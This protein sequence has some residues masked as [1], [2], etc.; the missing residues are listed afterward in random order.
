MAFS[1]I[2]F[3]IAKIV[4]NAWVN[5]EANTF[6]EWQDFGDLDNLSKS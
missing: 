4:L 1:K 2:V 3:L 6:Y 5:V